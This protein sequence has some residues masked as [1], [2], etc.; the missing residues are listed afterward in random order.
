MTNPC[1]LGMATDPS[2]PANASEVPTIAWCFTHHRRPSEGCAAG[3]TTERPDA[4][5]N[6]GWLLAICELAGVDIPSHPHCKIPG[7]ANQDVIEAWSESDARYK[8]EALAA[9]K[10]EGK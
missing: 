6:Y 7:S 3:V 8:R 4:L 2:Y 5:I 10:G 1:Q 9:L